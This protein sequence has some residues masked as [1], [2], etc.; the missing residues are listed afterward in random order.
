MLKYAEN[1]KKTLTRLSKTAIM[2]RSF[3]IAL[4]KMEVFGRG[5]E[6]FAM[7]ICMQKLKIHSWI[8]NREYLNNRVFPLLL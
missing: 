6:G 5:K 4:G 2:L 7:A 3:F 1:F 8:C